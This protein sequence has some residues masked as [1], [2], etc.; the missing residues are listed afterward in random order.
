MI[1]R[2]YKVYCWPYRGSI[3]S[4]NDIILL[5]LTLRSPLAALLAYEK[6][7][8]D[9]VNATV[10]RSMQQ[11]YIDVEAMADDISILENFEQ[12]HS[13]DDFAR[14][15][16]L[17]KLLVGAQVMAQK[18][19]SDFERYEKAVG[20][21]GDKVPTYLSSAPKGKRLEALKTMKDRAESTQARL[22]EYE[23]WLREKEDVIQQRLDNRISADSNPDEFDNWCSHVAA[24]DELIGTVKRILAKGEAPNG[25]SAVEEKRPVGSL[26]HRIKCLQ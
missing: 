10:R 12:E 26:A 16:H 18:I 24:M 21:A 22:D 7:W 25:S 13:K 19:T 17:T 3:W 2:L 20:E 9:R 1:V 4:Y 8:L 15:Q 23:T 5:L 11:V 14:L 6:N